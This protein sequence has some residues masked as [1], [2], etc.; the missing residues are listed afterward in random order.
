MRVD[1]LSARLR[2]E[3][4]WVNLQR[5]PA[6][7]KK[8]EPVQRCVMMLPPS[9]IKQIAD[10]RWARQMESRSAAA[11]RLIESGLIHESQAAGRK[12]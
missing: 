11:R 2:D 4:A 12:G 5:M 3:R 7:K 1:G 8:A 6:A 9:L 10:F